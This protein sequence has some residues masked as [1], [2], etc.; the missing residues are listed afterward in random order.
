GQSRQKF[1]YL[2]EQHTDFI[3]AILAEEFGLL[4]SL[5]VLGL[6]FFLAWRGYRLALKAPDTYG[7]L[8]AVGITTMICLQAFLNIGVVTGMLPVTGITLPFISAGGSSL[9]VTLTG[10]GI[11]LNISR[12]IRP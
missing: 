1:S 2:P 9:V 7:A 5:V 4:G 10:V 6:F 3:F 12:Q 8:L 11:L